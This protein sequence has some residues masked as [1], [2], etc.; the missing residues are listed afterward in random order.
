MQTW[1][2]PGHS[3]KQEAFGKNK[4]KRERAA[5]AAALYREPQISG[6]KHELFCPSFW[7]QPPTGHVL[8]WWFFWCP[9][10]MASS[11]TTKRRDC[12]WHWGIPIFGTEHHR[13][14]GCDFWER[15]EL[16]V[17]VKSRGET[18]GGSYVGVVGSGTQHGEIVFCFRSCY[19]TLRQFPRK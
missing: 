10:K 1:I 13:I 2:R 12:P 4:K 9:V 8:V 14:L 11:L 7:V 19:C 17:C 5:K 16:P 6:P 18:G 15:E 3:W